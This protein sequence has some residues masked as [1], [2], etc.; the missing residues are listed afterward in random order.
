[1]RHQPM[2][3]DQHPQR[4][5][6]P[7]QSPPHLLLPFRRRWPPQPVLAPLTSLWLLQGEQCRATLHVAP[8]LQGK[9]PRL[10][11]TW[12]PLLQSLQGAQR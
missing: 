8:E 2:Q 3:P 6:R 9:L 7:P 11:L 12:P 5:P 10:A 4:S 1:M